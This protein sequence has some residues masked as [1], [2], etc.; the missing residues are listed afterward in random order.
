M[1]LRIGGAALKPDIYAVSLPS[2]FAA[3]AAGQALK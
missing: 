3:V 1:V 2:R